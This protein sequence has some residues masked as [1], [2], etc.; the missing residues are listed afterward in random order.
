MSSTDLTSTTPTEIR[1]RKM[2]KDMVSEYGKCVLSV[3]LSS[4]FAGNTVL[5][6]HSEPCQH[7]T[8]L[9]Q[10]LRAEHFTLIIAFCATRSLFSELYGYVS[11]YDRCQS[12]W[13]ICSASFYSIQ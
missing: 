10:V 8:A 5:F 12:I 2:E 11:C 7:F 6:A 3:P 9:K 4:L 1:R 13:N